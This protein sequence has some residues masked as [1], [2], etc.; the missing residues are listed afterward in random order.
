MTN[1]KTKN[2]PL[3]YYLAGLIEGD[4]NISTEKTIGSPKGRKN[5]PQIMFTFPFRPCW[6]ASQ[7]QK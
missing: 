6:H 1:F 3:G 5:N 7:Q 2:K 4:G